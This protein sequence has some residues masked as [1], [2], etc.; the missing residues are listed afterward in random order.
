MIT[1]QFDADV[2]EL[3]ADEFRAVPTVHDAAVGGLAAANPC[4]HATYTTSSTGSVVAAVVPVAWMVDDD[5]VRDAVAV[6]STG[7]TNC[8][9]VYSTHAIAI[10]PAAAA[11]RV[12]KCSVPSAT[13]HH[14]YVF[15]AA[16]DT[17]AGSTGVHPDGAVTAK[18][19]AHATISSI[20]PA[21]GVP[22]SVVIAVTELDP[23]D[24]LP[25]CRA[26]G[27]AA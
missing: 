22:M 7:M 15:W 13:F 25:H 23:D 19:L 16:V 24:T 1:A 6:T 14:A 17:D 12:T 2:A 3:V 10:T 5:A 26:A 4:G 21:V 9:P 20:D 8:R 27:V 11:V 18:L